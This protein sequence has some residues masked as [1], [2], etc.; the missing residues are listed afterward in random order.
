MDE[1]MGTQAAEERFFNF[2]SLASF[3]ENLGVVK[4]LKARHANNKAKRMEREAKR[5]EWEAELKKLIAEE[6]AFY[7]LK[8]SKG[9]LQLSGHALDEVLAKWAKSE[10][11]QK[12]T[13][14]EFE[15]KVKQANRGLSKAELNSISDSKTVCLDASVCDVVS[16]F[17]STAPDLQTLQ[18]DVD[19]NVALAV[20][21]A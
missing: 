8:D 1:T 10:K 19:T 17:G 3:F 5:M 6:E 7:S 20:H 16:L 21:R 9:Q 14:L 11:I 18:D 4:R 2:S 15:E 13:R 12:L